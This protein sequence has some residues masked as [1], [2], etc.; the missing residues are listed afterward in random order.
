MVT[1][2]CPLVCVYVGK[3]LSGCVCT[4]DG[5]L[6][7]AGVVL[8]TAMYVR[9]YHTIPHMSSYSTCAHVCVCVADSSN[10]NETVRFR[11]EYN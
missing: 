3:Y 8:C 9:V 4:C 11:R 5:T 10:T 1:Q 2:V 7:S 6:T